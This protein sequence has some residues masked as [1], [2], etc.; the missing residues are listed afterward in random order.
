MSARLLD[1][2]RLTLPLPVVVRRRELDG[3]IAGTGT[4]FAPNTALAAFVLGDSD[5][6]IVF[7]AA[8]AYIRCGPAGEVSAPAAVDAID[9]VRRRLTLDRGAVFA[10]VLACGG[11]EALETLIPLRLTLDRTEIG[12]VIRRAPTY[13]THAA[14]EF[15]RGW[16]E[17]AGEDWP[18]SALSSELQRS[19]ASRQA[20]R[21]AR[22]ATTSYLAACGP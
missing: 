10:A 3:V 14:Q 17:L 20:V 7:R 13:R 8:V 19:R 1:Y 5:E 22:P 2:W 4:S 18:E 6:D 16:F 12:T 21:Q 9:W 15:L 11:D